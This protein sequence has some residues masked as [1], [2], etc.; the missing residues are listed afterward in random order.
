MQVA[1]D[2]CGPAALTKVHTSTV[3]TMARSLLCERAS[4]L[5]DKFEGELGAVL[6]GKT[7][8]LLVVPAEAA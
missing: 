4:P 3:P 7:E 5:Q 2:G 6:T 8:P 1:V